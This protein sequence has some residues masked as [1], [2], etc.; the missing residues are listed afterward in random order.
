MP[1]QLRKE[2]LMDIL[3]LFAVSRS[4]YTGVGCVG[5]AVVKVGADAGLD[6]GMKGWYA[7]AGG[8]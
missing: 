7:G 3:A 5:T 8:A 6:T 2:L 1:S 4:V